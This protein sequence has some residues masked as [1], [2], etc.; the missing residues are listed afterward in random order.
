MGASR[1][2]RN[3]TYQQLDTYD[4]LAR[5]AVGGPLLLQASSEIVG[6]KSV[7]EIP[8]FVDVSLFA[9]VTNDPSAGSSPFQSPRLTR[10][11]TVS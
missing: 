6:G 10:Y 5:R 2:V 4:R 3:A 11:D 7:F 9:Q 1:S 8:F